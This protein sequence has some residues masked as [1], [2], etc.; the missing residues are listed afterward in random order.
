MRVVAQRVSQASVRVRG[1]VTGQIGRGLC[2][3]IGVAPE[4]TEADAEKL[5]L[6]VANLRI[7]GSPSDTDD[8]G[9]MNHSL[10]EVSGAVLAVSQF[11]LFA[12]C[13]KGRRPSFTGAAPAELGRELYGRFVGCLEVLGVEVAC[14][15][16]GAVMKLE[17]TNE[18]P[19][20]IILDS[21]EYIN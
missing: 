2:L 19:V 16:F 1:R 3:L 9:R 11:T 13:K 5:A 12:D 8:D 18:G 14:G 6:K 21:T 15:E 20:T 17:I 10:L 4:D 7:F